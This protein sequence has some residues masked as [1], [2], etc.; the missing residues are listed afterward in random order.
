MLSVKNVHGFGNMKE[1]IDKN[2]TI[3]K[4]LQQKYLNKDNR[5]ISIELDKTE[6]NNLLIRLSFDIISPPSLEERTYMIEFAE[7]VQE[8][9]FDWFQILPRVYYR[10]KK[11][12][13]NA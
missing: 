1:N 10:W 5:L 13:F 3:L 8:L 7:E 6:E 11:N 4:F 12:N 9:V 2:Y